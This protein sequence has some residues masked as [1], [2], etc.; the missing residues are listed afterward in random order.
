MIAENVET[1]FLVTP[2]RHGQQGVNP[3]FIH[4][5]FGR[6][7]RGLVSRHVQNAVQL[8]PID[9]RKIDRL[10]LNFR[11]KVAEIFRFRLGRVRAEAERRR[12]RDVDGGREGPRL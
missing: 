4:H 1:D 12:H 9:K 8:R 3:L 10:S 2:A 11:G 6:H 7:C 5:Q